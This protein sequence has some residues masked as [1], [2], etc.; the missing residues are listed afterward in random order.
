M[1]TPTNPFKAP[2][3]YFE[4]FEARFWSRLAAQQPVPKLRWYQHANL[5]YA[6]AAV[7]I[8]A[9]GIGF[10]Q[11]NSQT[12]TVAT[13]E[14]SPISDYLLNR[15]DWDAY[16]M[17]DELDAQKIDELKQTLNPA[18]SWEVASNKINFDEVYDELE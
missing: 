5:W 14:L 6:C 9:L 15:T 4:D 18:I 8:L 1:S 7:L 16:D 10:S 11:F 2:E 3:Q 12:P 13:S 17:V